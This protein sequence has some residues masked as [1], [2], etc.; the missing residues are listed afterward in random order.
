VKRRAVKRLN[1]HPIDGVTARRQ[2]AEYTSHLASKPEFSETQDVLPF[3]KSRNDLSLLCAYY[4]PNIRNID[5][6]AHEFQIYGDFRAD[7][8]VGDS[9]AR[10]YL[11]IEFEDGTPHSVFAKSPKAAPDW[12][13]RFEGAF[14]QII[15]WLWKLDDMR[16]TGDFQNVFG[17]RD[18]TFRTLI[19]AGKAMNLPAQERDRLKWRMDKTVVDSKSVAFV[20]FDDM[21]ADMDFWLRNYLRA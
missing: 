18:A 1:T 12:S 10:N 15:D 17:G 7:M 14:S 6:V 13:T 9:A 5:V 8:I 21:A 11:L 16:S 20:S 3:F 4:F 2:W 19:V